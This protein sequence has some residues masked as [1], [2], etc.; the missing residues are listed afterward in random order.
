VRKPYIYLA[1][2]CF[3]LAVV[4]FVFASGARRI[5]SGGFFALLGIVNVVAARKKVSG[6]GRE[7]D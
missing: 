3:V 6:P 1:I 4:I 7:G 2:A 5:Y